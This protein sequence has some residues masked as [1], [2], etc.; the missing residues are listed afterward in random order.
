MSKGVQDTKMI[1]KS[2]ILVKDRSEKKRTAIVN[3]LKRYKEIIVQIQ[4][5]CPWGKF[6]KRRY[7]LNKSCKEKFWQSKDKA[8]KP[9]ESAQVLSKGRRKTEQTV[10]GISSYY[11]SDK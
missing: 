3:I 11:V 7:T 1:L 9:A 6:S 4:N 8:R 10:G 2:Y 5:S